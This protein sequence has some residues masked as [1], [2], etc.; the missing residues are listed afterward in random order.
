MDYCLV[1]LYAWLDPA[2]LAKSYQ[3]NF[4]QMFICI[5]YNEHQN[6]DNQRLSEELGSL[7][8][9]YRDLSTPTSLPHAHPHATSFG[10]KPA[11]LK[12]SLF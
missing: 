7:D 2:M 1:S 12:D 10:T 4:K 3:R 5:F 11:H 8:T 9:G 6:N